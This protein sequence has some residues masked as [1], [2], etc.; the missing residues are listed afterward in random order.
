MPF[1]LTLLFWLNDK[2]EDYAA[3]WAFLDRRIAEVLKVAGRLGKGVTKALSLP[4][5]LVGA[6]VPGGRPRGPMRGARR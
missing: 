6:A 1:T 5:R 2:S 4:E 3:T